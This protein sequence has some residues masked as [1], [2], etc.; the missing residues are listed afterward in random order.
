MKL[1]PLLH[2][3]PDLGDGGDVLR[4][5][6][7]RV[8]GTV[9]TQGYGGDDAGGCDETEGVEDVAAFGNRDRRP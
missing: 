5:G 6:L 4:R 3:E 1:M 2:V 7:R 9:L 8:L